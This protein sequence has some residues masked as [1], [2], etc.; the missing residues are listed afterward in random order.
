[1][2]LLRA[3]GEVVL[4]DFGAAELTGGAGGI[5]DGTLRGSHTPR[6]GLAQAK[7]GLAHA[8]AGVAGT[9]LYFPPEQFHGA[10]SSRAADPWAVGAILWEAAT[11]GP[12]RSHAD[13]MRGAGAVQPLSD[14]DR[15]R[16][17][18]AHGPDLLR[19]LLLLLG[20][21]PALRLGGLL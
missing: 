9:P 1:N 16:I 19:L 8:I 12:L 2:L 14:A 7:P 4:A 13:L 21:V 15:A 11:G 17:E 3:P 20:D 5:V 18:A 6:E 10:P